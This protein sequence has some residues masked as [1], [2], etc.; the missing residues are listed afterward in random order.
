LE[1]NPSYEKARSWI[2]KTTK[3]IMQNNINV[4]EPSASVQPSETEY[5]NDSTPTG[6]VESSDPQILPP[7]DSYSETRNIT[8][9][10]KNEPSAM[11]Q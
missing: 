4:T 3:E 7:P 10:G 6:I 5:S 2:E 8:E 9:F 11:P 1:L